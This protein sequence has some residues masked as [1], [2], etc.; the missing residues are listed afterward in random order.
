MLARH[1]AIMVGIATL[2][3][4]LCSG[5]APRPAASGVPLHPRAGGGPPIF[6]ATHWPTA[7]EPLG[8][9]PVDARPP[10]PTLD[11]E[12]PVNSRPPVLAPEPPFDLQYSFHAY[13]GS[14][15]AG[16]G[17]TSAVNNVIYDLGAAPATAPLP[18]LCLPTAGGV[19][20]AVD[21]TGNTLASKA[22][23]SPTT[24]P[25][26]CTPTCSG[27][28]THSE[29][30]TGAFEGPEKLLEMWFAP[31]PEPARSI[32][33]GGGQPA[34]G[35]LR[36][37]PRAAWQQMLDLVHCQVLSTL[38]NEHVD[39][40]LLS[41]SSF[42]VYPHKL[43][44]K[45]CGTTTL[46]Y[47]VPRIL[48]IAR[49]FLGAAAAGVYQVF[50]SRKNFMFPDQQ[51]EI[52]QSWDREVAYLDALFPD[53]AA[54]MI[55]KTNSDHWNVY[56]CGPYGRQDPAD[57]DA[58]A[59]SDDQP[60]LNNSVTGSPV[61]HPA[62]SRSSSRS[63]IHGGNGGGGGGG[64]GSCDARADVTVEILMTG[65]DAKRM[66]LMHLGGA[67]STE[68]PAGGKAVEIASGIAAIYPE[69]QSDSYLFT[70]CGF[71]L[72]GLQ[73]DGYYTIHVTPEQHCSYASFETT[74]ADGYDLCDPAALKRLVER[75]AA[76]FGPRFVTVTV[77]KARPDFGLRRRVD[78]ALAEAQPPM[79]GARDALAKDLLAKAARRLAADAAPPSFAPVDGYR[80]LDRVLYEFD[81]YWL[82]YAYYARAD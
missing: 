67:S 27:S 73:G 9:G 16:A 39:S 66:E 40:Y 58:D 52:H 79:A 74:I 75:V 51:V 32:G 82:R 35:G 80:A 37:V 21:A 36:R 13:D 4:G 63:T 50:Y 53:G 54:Y 65:L 61:I 6:T 18:L 17:I 48:E 72:N 57:A 11:M 46:L 24:S 19:E 47:A 12:Y 44:L 22:Q 71:S 70:P 68:G 34:R 38:S 41:E 45:T 7:T 28:G 26:T 29:G 56:L 2:A 3:L 55:G 33:Q 20:N 30:Y 59:D 14:G 49:E 5:A 8:P 31:G 25:K 76:V 43:V 77:F 15:L 42:F 23:T 64:G 78:S 62:L 10:Q 1:V 60:T 69:S 81:H